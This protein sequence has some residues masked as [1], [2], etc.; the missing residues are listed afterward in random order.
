M[1]ELN[2]WTVD[3]ES[4]ERTVAREKCWRAGARKV[5]SR[6]GREKAWADR[7][8][9]VEGQ[10]LDVVAGVASCHR[11]RVEIGEV[12]KEKEQFVRAL[13]GLRSAPT[14]RLCAGLSRFP[15]IRREF[16]CKPV[17]ID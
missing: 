17:Y 7:L 6:R 16:G 9:V 2:Q 1:S 3:L 5:S 12:V 8:V 15:T 10:Q 4:S 14:S 13:P 11:H